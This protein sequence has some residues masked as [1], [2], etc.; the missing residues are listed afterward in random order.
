MMTI[1]LAQNL[2]KRGYTE[3]QVF[4]TYSANVPYL[5]PVVIASLCMGCPIN[6]IDPSVE[7]GTILRM[8]ES[9]QPKAVFCEARLYDM[10]AECLVELKN[11]AKMFT[12]NGVEGSSE[13]VENLFVETGTEEDYV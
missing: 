8:F 11:D 10:M 13:P 4:G 2:Q 9:T 5:A 6:S 12:F 1:R 3:G 7:K